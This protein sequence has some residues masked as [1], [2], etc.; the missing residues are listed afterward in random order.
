MIEEKETNDFNVL[1]KHESSIHS[2]VH[3]NMTELLQLCQNNA[4]KEHFY[5]YEVLDA[6]GG[7]IGGRLHYKFDSPN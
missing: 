2:S 7:V 4:T 3:G 1:K 6:K 5:T